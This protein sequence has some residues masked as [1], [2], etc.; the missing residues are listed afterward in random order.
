LVEA[1]QKGPIVMS[2]KVARSQEGGAEA[3]LPLFQVPVLRYQ[4]RLE[5]AFSGEAFDR[6]VTSAD[7][8]LI[9][10]FLPKTVVPTDQGV[11]DFRLKRKGD[12]MVVPPIPVPYD[13][14]PMIFLV[15]DKGGRKK[16]LTD[17]TTHLEA[18]RTLCAK[19]ADL[20]EERA[21]ADKFLRDLDA[22]DKNLS[23]AAYDSAV[24]GFLHVYGSQVSADLQ[25]FLN[26]G[27]SNLDKFQFLTQ[28]FRKTNVLVPQNAAASPVEAQVAVS[29]G[30]GKAVSAYV[31]IVFD[32]AVIIHNLWPGH[33][34]QY[35]P[36]LA[37]NFSGFSA[38]LFYSDWVRTTGDLRG[39]LLC[40]PGKWEDLLPPAFDL[41]LPPGEALLKKQVLLKV[42]LQDKARP[43]FALFGHGW[44]LLVA[45][46]KGETLPPIPL[47]PSPGRQG[48]VA[49]AA[50][51]QEPLRKLG[52]VNAKARIVGNWGFTSL[53]SGPLE[54]A[55]GCDPAWAPAPVEAAAFMAGKAC[56]IT[57]PGTWAACVEKAVFRPASGPALTAALEDK[58]EGV[59]AAAFK[60]APDQGG[61]G[62]LD[63]YEFGSPKAALSVPL[64]LLE[65]WPETSAV[66]ARQGEPVLLVRGSHLEGIV[67]V[68]LG[69]R[70]FLPVKG[71]EGAG[72]GFRTE[73]GKPMEGTLGTPCQ[74]RLILKD[75]T[76]RSLG[77]VALLGPRPRLGEVQVTVAESKGGALTLASTVP[78]APTG[79]PSQVSLLAEKGYRFPGDRA[80]Q[81]AFRNAEEPGEVRLVPASRIKVM[82]NNQKALLAF[83]PQ[84]L[85]GGRASGKLELQ[86]QDQHA[87]ASDWCPLP[88]TFVDLPT[89]GS[90]RSTG[91]T[92]LLSGPSLDQIEWIAPAPGGPWAKLAVQ[93][94]GGQEVATL[95]APSQDGLYGIRLF[96]WPD[97]TLVL[98]APA[99]L[100]PAAAPVEPAH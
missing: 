47:T 100:P 31:S 58:P 3:L 90:L 65:P 81:V 95:P 13:S 71:A 52:A 85:L 16:V 94:V 21:E 7:W 39:A 22:I 57:L 63:L 78:I 88:A 42:R 51:L 43:P 26:R 18:F 27:T 74:G 53:A 19:I 25:G 33:Q 70:R 56:A 4:D 69:E 34:F 54:L 92:F 61:P 96:G 91:G 11:V 37:R 99:P 64:A 44:K 40:C 17:L 38:D 76:R 9:V 30:Q 73:D 12:L 75:G 68:E 36:A 79:A 80:F 50:L 72:R 66:E 98:K 35:L 20:S 45:G 10:V 46:P 89:L 67:A 48:F 84:E 6:R 59:R 60:P 1:F 14:I 28:E 15:P 23:P 97:L 8:S 55:V 2:A 32:L 82:G 5:L 93:L 77:A 87:G 49:S 24:A 83:N 29:A 62:H 86:V 41:E